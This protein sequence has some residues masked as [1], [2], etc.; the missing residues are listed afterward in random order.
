[1]N[2]KNIITTIV[3]TTV[4]AVACLAQTSK[5]AKASTLYHQAIPTSACKVVYGT[6]TLTNDLKISNASTTAPLQLLC[7]VPNDSGVSYASVTAA[8]YGGGYSGTGF[9]GCTNYNMCMSLCQERMNDVS[10]CSYVFGG[11]SQTW[12]TASVGYF[13]RSAT[14][15]ATGMT[16]GDP[17]YLA[18]WINPAGSSWQVFDGYT[19]DHY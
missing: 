6:A 14:Y 8:F 15:L 13:E 18:V 19:V 16:A 5:P 7:P 10:T 17:T 1:M 2:L 3:C 12:G 9:D 11:Y 4:L